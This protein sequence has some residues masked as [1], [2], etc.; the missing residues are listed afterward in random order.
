[1][2]TVAMGDGRASPSN[3]QPVGRLIADRYELQHLLGRGSLGAVYKARHVLIDRDVAIKLL[4]PERQRTEG[5]RSWLLQEARAANRVNHPNIAQIYDVGTTSDELL[6]LVME[7]V[8]GPRLDQLIAE[9]PMSVDLAVEIVQQ[10]AAALARAHDLGVIHRDLKPEHIFVLGGDGPSPTVKII[11]FGLARIANRRPLAAHG[12]LIGTPDY[13]A[14]EQARGE[15]VGPQADL[16]ALGAVLYAMLTGHPPFADLS[17]SEILDRKQTEPP[18][19]VDE[20]RGETPEP[21]IELVH[22]LLAVDI[23]QRHQD[24]YHVLDDCRSV[25]RAAPASPHSLVSLQ[26]PVTGPSTADVVGRWAIRAALVARMV[27]AVHADHTG[28]PKVLAAVDDLWRGVADLSRVVGE[29]EAV[30]RWDENLRQRS[31][32]FTEQV[33]S[34]IEE[35]SR[36]ESRLRREMDSARTALVQLEQQ[37]RAAETARAAA[38]QAAEAFEAS[39]K[40]REASRALQDAGAAAALSQVRLQSIDTVGRKVE[41]WEAECRQ[42]ERQ[43]ELLREQLERHASRLDADLETGRPRFATLVNERQ[44]VVSRLEDAERA[45]VNHLGPRPECRSLLYQLDAARSH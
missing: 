14:P 33:A 9:G 7:L 30:S 32:D 36:A 27:A 37:R 38:R 29:L 31:R 13:M 12:A 44:S 35:L 6:Y 1:M 22:R 26:P 15:E 28:P 11:D 19:R 5:L 4:D 2:Y 40:A 42:L 3:C 45:V 25:P 43:R 18:R 34:R 8:E 24:A 41:R 21:L 39:H 17:G 10:T 16:Y 23:R 20:L